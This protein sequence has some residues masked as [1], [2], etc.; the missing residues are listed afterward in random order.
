MSP[1]LLRTN[2]VSGAASKTILAKMEE[3][4]VKVA[5]EHFLNISSLGLQQKH[6]Y[7]Q[8]SVTKE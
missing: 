6:I 3:Y 4:R 8:M 7:I 2:T 5:S 1:R